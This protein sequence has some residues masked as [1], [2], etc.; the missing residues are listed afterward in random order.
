[1]LSSFCSTDLVISLKVILAFHS[2]SGGWAMVL[3][4][5]NGCQ[6]ETCR[7]HQRYCRSNGTTPVHLGLWHW[8]G[9]LE[10]EADKTLCDMLAGETVL[11]RSET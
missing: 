7:T 6:K 5:P 1:M 11:A 10:A 8:I 2:K 3:N 4:T 9:L